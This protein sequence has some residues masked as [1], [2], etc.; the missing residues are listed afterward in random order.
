MC[1]D[2]ADRPDVLLRRADHA[3]YQAKTRSEGSENKVQMFEPEP[4][5]AKAAQAVQAEGGPAKP[6][7]PTTP[8]APGT[9]VRSD[10][11]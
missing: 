3:M 7:A 10:P 8:T 6:A 5:C 9:A 11:V 2:D 4:L 1:P